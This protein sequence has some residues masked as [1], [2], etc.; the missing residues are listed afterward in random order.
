MLGDIPPFP[1]TPSWCGAQF[2]KSTLPLLSLMSRSRV[3]DEGDDLQIWRVA[4]NT[5]NK[6]SGVGQ[7]S[8]ISS[9]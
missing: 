1:N 5:L 9:P 3:A 4:V 7:G 2:K 8:K 6:Q